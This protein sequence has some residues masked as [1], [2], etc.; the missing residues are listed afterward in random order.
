MSWRGAIDK[1]EVKFT[2]HKNWKGM[3]AIFKQSLH[4]V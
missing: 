4:L 2:F 3:I 1:Y